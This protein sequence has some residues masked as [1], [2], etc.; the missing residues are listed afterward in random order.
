MPEIYLA[1]AL[2]ADGPIP[3][4]HSMLSLASAAYQRDKTL[5]STFTVNLEE[6]P[7][8]KPNPDTL[9]WWKSK[10]EAWQ[11]CR[12]NPEPAGPAIREY[13]QWLDHLPGRPVYVGYPAASDY[14]FVT[15]YLHRFADR[16]PFGRG[17]MD[18][19]TFAMALLHKP[20]HQSKTRHMPDDW[21]ADAKP[22]TFV[23]LDDALAIGQLLCHM[24]DVWNAMPAH[25]DVEPPEPPTPHA[26]DTH[27]TI[28]LK[29]P[30]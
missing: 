11:R 24:L 10:P 13:A 22:H 19:R 27:D 30:A 9:A 5:V 8:A 23:A 15:W 25:P 3:G 6:L 20:Y 26:M 17:A 21:Y 7:D 28:P 16:N 29:D 1:T 2:E 14:A 4:P 18:L 12:E